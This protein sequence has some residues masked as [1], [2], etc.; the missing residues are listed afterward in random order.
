V[1]HYHRQ[2]GTGNA[3]LND[4]VT[5][6][7]TKNGQ[8]KPK[9][10]HKL[11]S[12]NNMA[13]RMVGDDQNVALDIDST[14][15][16]QLDENHPRFRA[17]AELA[18]LSLD[19]VF[20]TFARNQPRLYLRAIGKILVFTELIAMMTPSVAMGL[21]WVTALCDGPPLLSI[22]ELVLIV[23]NCLRS[24]DCAVH[25]DRLQHCIVKSTMA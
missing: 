14:P 7:V 23:V 1:E 5:K 15:A 25:N 16:W 20:L 21:Q 10:S 9:K 19:S 8:K 22:I 24:G 11:I 3:I 18:D 12:H 13:N 17:A 6:S 4:P 2:H